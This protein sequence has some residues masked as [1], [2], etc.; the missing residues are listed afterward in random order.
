MQL[1]LAPVETEAVLPATA[2]ANAARW[3][4]GR[5]GR[6]PL[7]HSF[8]GHDGV[9][10]VPAVCMWPSPLNTS[11]LLEIQELEDGRGSAATSAC[12]ALA[13]SSASFC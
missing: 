8:M 4:G 2:E 12:P 5:R 11:R 9:R 6:R 7:G 1:G 13:S 3:E 10:P